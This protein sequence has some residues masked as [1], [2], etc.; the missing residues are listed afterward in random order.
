MKNN[1]QTIYQTWLAYNNLEDDLRE[2]LLIIKS[3]QKEIEERFYKNLE[4]GTGGLRGILG[5]GLNRMNKYTVRKATAGLA[6]FIISQGKKAMNMGVVIAYDS[7]KYSKEFAEEAAKVLANKRIKVFV[8]DELRPT[9]LLSFAVRHYGAYAGI[10]VTAS[11]NPPEYNG[12]KVYNEDGNQITENMADLIFN[13]IQSIENPLEVEVLDYEEGQK[14][15][16]I[17]IIGDEVDQAYQKLVSGLLI[18]PNIVKEQGDQLSIV[19]TPLHGTGNKPVRKILKKVGFSN[20]HIVKEQELP[21]ET[22]ATVKAPNPEER[23]VYQL[24]LELANKVNA[25]L[26]MATDPDADRLGI[27]VKDNGNYIA[28]NG[29]QLG[30][31]ILYY[32]ITQKVKK[33]ILAD[34]AI[35]VKTIVTSNLGQQIAEKNNVAVENTLTGFKYIGE[36]IKEYITLNNQTYLFGYEESYG[37]L[38]GD[39]VRDKDAVQTTMLVSE[40]ALVYKNQ[41]KTLFDVLEEIY[42]EYGYYQEDLLSITLKGKDGTE[43]IKGIVDS[44]RNN[45]LKTVNGIKVTAIEDYSLQQRTDYITNEKK[46]L[47][48]PKS[49]VIK[50]IL[51]DDSWIAIRPSGTEP[52]LKFY[53]S[54]VANT[55]EESLNKLSEMKLAVTEFAKV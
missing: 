8:F 47:E 19:Y 35:L 27:L 26:I 20:L 1:Y 53:F 11:H 17:T 25:D 31:L 46:R 28:L 13:E 51:E 44:F 6:S 39:F 37:Y 48:L 15:N 55:R 34:N 24:A 42:K 16:L 2:E 10:V 43:K 4:F 32:L 54:S 50:L 18:N 36:K 29:N 45:P 33:G 38:I 40:M 41:N 12:Y 7:R 9:P 30:A 49:N 21:D 3:N 52:K 22:F 23:E 14:E 5:A